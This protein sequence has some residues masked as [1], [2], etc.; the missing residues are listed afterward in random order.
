M[1]QTTISTILL[2]LAGAVLTAYLLH[3]RKRKV[4]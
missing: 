3:R 4:E 1:D 2:I